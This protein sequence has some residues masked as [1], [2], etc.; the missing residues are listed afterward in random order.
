M[1]LLGQRNLLLAGGK[2][3]NP[4]SALP[5]AFLLW[6]EKRPVQFICLLLSPLG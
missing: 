3:L 5:G 2:L 6:H 4:L 1:P